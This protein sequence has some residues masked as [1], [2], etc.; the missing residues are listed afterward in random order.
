MVSTP[1]R[2][3][4]EGPTRSGKTVQLV[5]HYRD[6]VQTDLTGLERSPKRIKLSRRAILQ[7]SASRILVFA[8]TG[9]NRLIL[10]DRLLVATGGQCSIQSKTPLSFFE[11]EVVLFW[12]LLIQKLSLKAQFPIRLRPEN[13]QEL[14]TQLWRSSLTPTLL[15]QAGVGEYRMVRRLLDLIQLAALSGTPFEE[16]PLLMEQGFPEVLL[17]WSQLG[18]LQQQWRT[19]C[20][21]RGLL[22]YGLLTELYGR[23]LL[24]DPTYQQQLLQR[25][26]AVLADDVDNYPAIMRDLFEGLLDQ[27]TIGVFTFN[28]NGASRLGLG[29]DP[30][31]LE[32]LR[33]HCEAITLPDLASSLGETVANNIVEL[34]SNPLFLY[35]IPETVQ[36]IQTFSRA[37]LLRRTAE[38][39]AEGV[40]S[41]QVQPQE[42]VVI[43]PGLDAIARYSLTEI[44]VNKGIAVERLND[45]RPLA[46]SPFVQALLTLM[47]LVYPGLGRL[48]DRDSVTEMLVVLSQKPRVG[49]VWGQEETSPATSSDRASLSV[50]PVID[51]VRASLLADYCFEPH[52]DRPRLLPIAAFPRWDRLGYQ[53]ATA[54][55]EILNWIEAQK[56][57]KEQRLIPSPLSLLDRAIQRFLWN[58]SSLSYDKLAALRELMET[59]QH[60]WEVETRLRQSEGEEPAIQ[61]PV[62]RFIQLLRSGTIT[63]DPYPVRPLGMIR[64]AVML[65]NIFQYRSNRLAHRWQ[66]WLDA[67]SPRWFTGTEALYGSP[68]FLQNWSGRPW[69][70]VDAIAA[71]EQRLRRV[72]LDL[73]GR[74]TERVFLCHSDLSINGQ[75]QTGSLLALVNASVP[76]ASDGRVP[77]E[78]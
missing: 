33:T 27:G 71:Q 40:R 73:L 74:T 58:G 54:Y 48:V 42:V 36:S 10:T 13:E 64:P 7:R 37:Q 34:V 47:A 15:Q 31:Y 32:R 30:G 60:Y 65:A 2:L 22:T 43:A 57:Q 50:V 68:L 18:A 56:E 52:P 76:I 4:I 38:V 63:A 41:G 19:W 62:G 20:L 14:A 75:E 1:L 11:D 59:A 49:Q 5:D 61:A 3:W 78:A 55:E 6:L 67:G 77:T 25:Y 53:A 51:F 28:P 17:P 21:E 44:L 26:Q 45:Q 29:A 24:P 39:I 46:S 69:S 23:Y 70:E 35:Q 16:I 9:D 12:P 8:D 66:F 72:L